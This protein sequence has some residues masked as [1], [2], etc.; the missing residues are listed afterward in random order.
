MIKVGES[1]PVSCDLLW[2]T[3]SSCAHQ[4]A[5]KFYSE[6]GRTRILGTVFLSRTFHSVP[7]HLR[8]RWC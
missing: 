8:L 2:M 3:R 4:G 6:Q 5:R 1:T 7:A